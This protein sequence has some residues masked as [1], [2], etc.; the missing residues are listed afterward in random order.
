MNSARLRKVIESSGLLTNRRQLKL[1]QL[2]YGTGGWNI[3]REGI[4]MNI[5]QEPVFIKCHNC[6]YI[7]ER[8]CYNS[9]NN[10]CTECGYHGGLNSK[11]RIELVLDKDSFKEMYKNTKFYDPLHFPEYE[12]KYKKA[13]KITGLDDAGVTGKG[14]INGI[15][16]MIGIMD[17]RFMMSSMGAIVG[18]KITKLFETAVGEKLPVIIFAASGGA[19]MQEGIISLMQM[20]K[21]S[22]AVA[23]F[24]QSGGF[25]ISVLT[26]PT[27][28]GVSASFAFLGDIILA[29]PM[30]LIGF[31]GKRVIEHTIN[32]NMPEKFQT[33]EYLLEHGFIDAIVQRRILK[34]R[35]HYLLELHNYKRG[36][37]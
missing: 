29:E 31:A 36:H 23:K 20:A 8:C 34:E 35:L 24:N 12:E 10:V 4:V 37:N 25:Y 33:S 7:L 5:N 13:Q 3:M 17:A 27:T 26:N 2:S 9:N 19:R 22:A 14:T 32:E 30:A 18:E 16:I 11:E 28:G 1:S 15:P 6:G 21:T